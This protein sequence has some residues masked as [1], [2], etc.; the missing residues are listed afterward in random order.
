MEIDDDSSPMGGVHPHL[1]ANALLGR[2]SSLLCRFRPDNGETAELPQPLKLSAFYPHAL[3]ARLSSLIHRSPPENDAP[4]ELQQPCT[5]LRLDPH[6]LLARLSSLF[7]RSR[8]GTD[9]EAEPHPTMPSGSRPDALISRLPSLFRFKPHTNGK[10]EFPQ[11]SSHPHVVEVAAV[12]DKQTLVVARGPKFEKAKRAYEQQTQSHG[13]TQASLSHVQHADASTSTTPP[14][15]GTSTTT[16]D[17]ATSQ[18]LHI[19]C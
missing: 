5:P 11:L 18:S 8:L 7:P 16:A 4:D 14:A 9:E 12:R 10:T 1:S 2:L 15:P 6:V 3:L 19:Q 17:A 13:R